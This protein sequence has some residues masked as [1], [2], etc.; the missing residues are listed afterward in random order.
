MKQS[1]PNKPHITSYAGAQGPMQHMPSSW[2]DNGGDWDN[3]GI[4]SPHDYDDAT[5]ASA[6]HLCTSN[7]IDGSVEGLQKAL[8]R[9]YTGRLTGSTQGE[10]YA[11]MVIVR[12]YTY[13][14]DNNDNQ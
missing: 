7:V 10:W 1:N 11:N 2:Q 12:A 4:N 13:G 5:A 3:D 6:K 8:S 9:Y 14:M